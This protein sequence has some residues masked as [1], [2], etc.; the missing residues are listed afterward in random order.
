MTP[1]LLA[2]VTSVVKYLLTQV[3]QSAAKEGSAVIESQVRA[4]FTRFR[5]AEP[6]AAKARPPLSPEQL[7]HIRQLAYEEACADGLDAAKAGVLADSIIGKLA[8]SPA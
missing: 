8:I 2:A 5:T 1:A 4:L 7:S 3:E 6:A